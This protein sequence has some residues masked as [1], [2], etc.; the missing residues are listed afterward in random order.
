MAKTAKRMT[1]MMAKAA[2]KKA[3]P[4]AEAAAIIKTFNTTNLTRQSRS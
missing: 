4:V 1:A 3:V 2:N